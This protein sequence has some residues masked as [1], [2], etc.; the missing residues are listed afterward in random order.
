MEG[1][2]RDPRQRLL[3]AH[4]AGGCAVKLTEILEFL[5]ELSGC[6]P[7][8]ISNETLQR[9]NEIPIIYG[10]A[11]KLKEQTDWSPVYTIKDTLEWMYNENR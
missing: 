6:R 3:L 5:G 2:T 7:E 9:K 8:I 11:H 1:R 4:N 10:S